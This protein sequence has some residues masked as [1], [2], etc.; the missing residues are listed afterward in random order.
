MHSFT[1]L[2]QNY[3]EH[4]LICFDDSRPPANPAAG[5]NNFTNRMI[6][7]VVNLLISDKGSMSS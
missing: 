5:L 3:P 2:K 7:Y 1:V 4:A 6:D